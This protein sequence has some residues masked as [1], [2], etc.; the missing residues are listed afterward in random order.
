MKELT[1]TKG[2]VA[3]VDDEDFERLSKYKWTYLPPGYARRN[4]K[5][6]GENRS[7]ALH[8]EVLGITD[9]A[10]KV[11]HINRNGLD[12]R[13]ANLRVCTNQQNCRNQRGKGTG[14]KGV[15]LH[16][17][18]Y[19]ARIKV[20]YNDKNLGTFD[21]AEEAARVYDKAAKEMFGEF[22]VLNFEDKGT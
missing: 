15:S 2:H 1:L 20:D 8:R 4:S 5:A 12:N 10:I 19:R 18:R 13:R 3:I 17:G 16:Y 11:D 7:I 9:P 22:A 6:N 14:Y 21:S